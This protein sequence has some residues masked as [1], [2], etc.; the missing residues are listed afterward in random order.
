MEI[1]SSPCPTPVMQD[2]SNRKVPYHGNNCSRFP[3]LLSNF[4]IVL[5]GLGLFLLPAFL[6]IHYLSRIRHDLNKISAPPKEENK[7]TS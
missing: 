3:N 1:S 4:L 6:V 7:K 5:L 2:L